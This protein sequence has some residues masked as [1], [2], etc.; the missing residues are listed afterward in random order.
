VILCFVI[1]KE[2]DVRNVKT[3]I[4]LAQSFIAIDTVENGG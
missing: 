1:L 3:N 2:K 4:K